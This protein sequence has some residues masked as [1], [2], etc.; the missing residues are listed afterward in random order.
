MNGAHRSSGRQVPRQMLIACVVT[1][2]YTVQFL[3]IER[4]ASQLRGRPMNSKG[5]CDTNV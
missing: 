1:R 2:P 5:I 3:A 4:G